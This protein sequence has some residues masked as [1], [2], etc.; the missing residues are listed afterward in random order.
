MRNLLIAALLSLS[1]PQV[2]DITG[3]WQGTLGEGN[4]KIRMVLRIA[5][6]RNASRLFSIDQNP[7]WGA[8]QDLTPVALEGTTFKFKVA[9][10]GDF[11]AFEGILDSQTAS[12]R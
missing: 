11:G 5:K 12:I 9:A 7:D 1:S 8:G 6:E 4:D 2:Q 3:D 10:Q